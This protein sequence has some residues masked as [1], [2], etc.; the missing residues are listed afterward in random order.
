[1]IKTGS[2]IEKDIFVLVKNS[3][4][5]SSINGGVYRDE[6]RPEDST[7]EDAVII[8]INGLNGD[9]Q[10][11]VVSINVYVPDTLSGKRYIKNVKRCN[12]IETL[13]MEFANSIPVNNYLIKANEIISTFENIPKINQ[14]YVNVK[15]KFLYNTI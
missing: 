14:H 13:C 6:L 15:L 9:T 10:V 11:G 4:L 3:T 8:F 5:A 1:M 12:E 2:D 7:K